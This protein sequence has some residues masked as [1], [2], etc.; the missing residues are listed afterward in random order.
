MNT[1]PQRS[2]CAAQPRE[3]CASREAPQLLVPFSAISAE[4]SALLLLDQQMKPL[5]IKFSMSW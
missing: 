1:D 2:V 3:S 4:G 5:S